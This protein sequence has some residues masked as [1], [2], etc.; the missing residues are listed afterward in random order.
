MRMACCKLALA[1]A[2][3]PLCAGHCPGCCAPPR[4]LAVVAQLP[5]SRPRPPAI[6]AGPPRASQVAV[7]RGPARPKMHDFLQV[8][9]RLLFTAGLAGD[10]R[11]QME[12]VDLV[13][14]RFEDLEVELLCL[15]PL[16]SSVML[17]GR[18][19]P[20]PNRAHLDPQF[21]RP[22]SSE[23]ASRKNRPP[24]VGQPHSAEQ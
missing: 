14:I 24:P 5:E 17:P 16:A 13:T 21:E 3:R 19:E 22:D 15:R 20:L 10:H 4:G 11:Q 12:R 6:S 7:R 18:I 2:G 1:S 8:V 23:R 9:D